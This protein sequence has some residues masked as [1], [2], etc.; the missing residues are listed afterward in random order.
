MGSTYSLPIILGGCKQ[1][2]RAG[3]IPLRAFKVN[4]RYFF[5]MRMKPEASIQPSVHLA[6]SHTS[7]VAP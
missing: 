4:G 7:T 6:V 3:D 2:K 5:S 1:K